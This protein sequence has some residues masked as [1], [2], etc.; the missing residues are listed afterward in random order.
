LLI[1]P[2]LSNRKLCTAF[3]A[4]ATLFETRCVA[5]RLCGQLILTLGT[6]GGTRDGYAKWGTSVNAL[7]P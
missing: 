6:C 4:R 3:E 7:S 2:E 1:F 5:L